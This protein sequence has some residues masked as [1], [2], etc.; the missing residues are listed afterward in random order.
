MA[1]RRINRTERAYRHL[2]SE[3]VRG[4]WQAGET[5]STYALAEELGSSRTPVLEALKRLEQEG[6]V[7]I[8]PQVGCRVLRPG[9]SS[10]EELFTLRGALEGVAAAAAARRIDHGELHALEALLQQLE[11]AADRGD[12]IAYGDLDYRFH[13]GIIDASRM[14][15][16]VRIAGGV[17]SSLRS[18][19]ELLPVP[20]DEL[21]A[22][23]P[24]HRDIYTAL[25]RRA[26]ERARAAAERHAT[27]SG[28]RLAADLK[29]PPSRASTP[30][31]LEHEALLYA[32]DEEF[33]A[34][35]LPFVLDGLNG[36]D[37][38][39]SVTTRPNMKLLERAL[40]ANAEQIEFHD[41]GDWYQNPAD[42]LLAYQRYIVEH[43][44]GRRVRIVGE[45]V[46]HGAGA[47][48]AAITQWTRY[49][50]TL[51]V[52]CA[53]AP[54]SFLC[55]YDTRALPGAIVADA[56]RTHP[57]IRT[58]G[59]TAP[60]L[61]FTDFFAPPTDDPSPPSPPTTRS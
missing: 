42:T 40:G 52:A 43:A 27:Q 31:G 61:E 50:A 10:V 23:I 45:L 58:G 57:Q 39:L 17:W 47:S 56:Y 44:N 3:I 16:L 26:P 41:S 6:L 29:H 60:S 49:E 14:P 12:P 28:D 54:V 51:N 22:S 46:W 9:S 15:R 13:A 19:P 8:I 5:L 34:A 11:A 4:R 55:P 24:E 38:V 1:E 30:D 35:T 59:D 7:E 21:E 32:S 18:Q 20:G 48:P 36:G 53:L 2:A 37:R 25:E 33:L